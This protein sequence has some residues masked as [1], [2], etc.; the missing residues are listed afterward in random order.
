MARLE[1]LEQILVTYPA[2]V[3][4]GYT[5]V[6]GDGTSHFGLVLNAS[7]PPPCTRA[8]RAPS[9]GPRTTP[10]D[11]QKAEHPANTEAAVHRPTRRP[12]SA[13]RR[14]PRR[15]RSGSARSV[16]G[17]SQLGQYGQPDAAVS[18]GYVTGY[19]PDQ[20]RGHGAGGRR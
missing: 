6:P 9:S 8:T 10:R 15:P 2:N 7:D 13:A 17:G 19:D 20:R 14:T 4:G 11:R 1:G 16:P 3:A 5:V 12:R 18:P